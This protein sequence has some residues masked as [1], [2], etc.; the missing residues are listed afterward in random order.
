[1]PGV[2]CLGSLTR[3]AEL[4]VPERHLG[5]VSGALAMPPGWAEGLVTWA[6]A[7]DL[8][9]LLAL[10]RTPDVPPAAVAV[11]APRVRIGVAQ[12]AAFHFYYQDNLDLLRDAGAELVPFSPLADAQLPAVDG[13][14]IGG[15]Y[16]EEHHHVLS[17]NV[18][19]R[20]AIAAFQG[21]IYA[22]CGGLMYLGDALD[23]VPMC[24]V[25]PVATRMT[26]GLRTLGY[27]EVTLLRDTIL[28]PAGTVFRGHEFH[29]SELAATELEPAYRIVGR[30]GEG[31][32]GW[33][34]GRVLGSYVH[35]HFGSNP[36][37][38]AHLV[39]ACA[40]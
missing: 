1:V 36:A 30:L 21:P 5:L 24:G 9:A 25:L 37:L 39:N 15:G 28:G 8:A 31:V 16:P 3:Q 22:E 34:Q 14:Y 4:A 11:G 27:R 29:Y 35:A 13:L 23:G 32:E 12:D 38:A 19:M 26:A 17:A 2:A 40:R 10:A 18:A 6:E 33:G 7:L 20:A